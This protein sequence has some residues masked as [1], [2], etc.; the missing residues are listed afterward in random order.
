MNAA[1]K[2]KFQRKAAKPQRGESRNRISI[3]A[4]YGSFALEGLSKMA[5]RF[6]AGLTCL[7]LEGPEGWKKLC[8]KE[9]QPILPSLTGLINSWAFCSHR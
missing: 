2:D 5:Q 1:G 6:I 8:T 4:L 3:Q 7:A 9:Q